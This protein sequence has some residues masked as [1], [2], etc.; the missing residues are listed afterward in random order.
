MKSIQDVLKT[1]RM[2]YGD[3][4]FAK[5]E[6]LSYEVEYVSSQALLD[7]PGGYYDEMS[8]SE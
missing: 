5:A 8:K 1:V 2:L 7:G 4:V 3:A 6:R